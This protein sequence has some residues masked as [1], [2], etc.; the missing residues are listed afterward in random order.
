MFSVA[1]FGLLI[2]SFVALVTVF[3]WLGT[4]GIV[5]IGMIFVLI[6]LVFY[7]LLSLVRGVVVGLN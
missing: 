1:F 5:G 6:A 7:V 2:A 4:F 3:S